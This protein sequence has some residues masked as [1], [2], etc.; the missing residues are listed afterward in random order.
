M[1]N[2][3]KQWAYYIRGLIE[4]DKLLFIDY[5]HI[6][7]EISLTPGDHGIIAKDPWFWNCRNFL[8]DGNHW[9]DVNRTFF[10][11]FYASPISGDL[12][13]M[14]K[15]M[16][17]NSSLA[18]SY[19]SHHKKGYKKHAKYPHRTR[20][21]VYAPEGSSLLEAERVHW[22]SVMSRDVKYSS[23]VITFPEMV[24]TL[25]NHLVNEYNLSVRAITLAIQDMSKPD[26]NGD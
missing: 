1:N 10:M 19:L 9:I 4:Y 15:R 26:K 24:R 5:E 11:D 18:K 21:A 20:G 2:L 23:R 17:E 25:T 8:D 7:D 22:I 14:T 16:Q 13:K 3:Q 12:D 6:L